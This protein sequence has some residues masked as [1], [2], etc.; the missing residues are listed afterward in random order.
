LPCNARCCA[1]AHH[2]GV[3]PCPAP[4][5]AGLGNSAAYSFNACQTAAMRVL[6]H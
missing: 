1:A 5:L 6:R 3:Y 4:S 2:D